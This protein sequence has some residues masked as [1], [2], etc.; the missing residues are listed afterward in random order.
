[1][2]KLIIF[3]VL[4]VTG[5]TFAQ[6]PVN[7]AFKGQEDG[8]Y[9]EWFRNGNLRVDGNFINGNIHGE[10][11]TYNKNGSLFERIY[12]NNGKF[13]GHDTGYGKNDS[14]QTETYYKNDTL[15]YHKEFKYYKSGSLKA[16]RLVFFDST[17][18]A[19]NPF[20]DAKNP[21]IGKITYD[22]RKG[23]A[24]LK[25]SGAYRTFYQ[26]GQVKVEE[27]LINDERNGQCFIYY[28]S[29]KVKYEY[30][31]ENGYLKGESKKYNK[32]GELIKTEIW[33][34]GKKISTTKQ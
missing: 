25:S 26:N 16:E 24:T 8:T 20:I 11:K 10:W 15:V 5:S 27:V 31:C 34:K 1:M 6:N 21:V 3:I 2:S 18:L 30:F 7:E 17:A 4:F 13:H 22:I 23:I 12:F 29:G 14:I 19:L 32:N 33:E 28:E 9:Q